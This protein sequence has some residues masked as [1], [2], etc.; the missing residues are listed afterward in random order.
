MDFLQTESVIIA[1]VK[2]SLR[3]SF[4]NLRLKLSE[5]LFFGKW[6]NQF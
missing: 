3:E 4:E 5:F 1:V 6:K 2:N